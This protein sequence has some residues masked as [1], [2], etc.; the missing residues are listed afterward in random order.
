M[1]VK[2]LN[3]DLQTPK[4]LQTIGIKSSVIKRRINP[5]KVKKLLDIVPVL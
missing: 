3:L 5:R 2:V 4:S 1:A